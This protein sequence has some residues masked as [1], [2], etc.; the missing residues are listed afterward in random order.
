MDQEAALPLSKVEKSLAAD[1]D[2]ADPPAALA[3]PSPISATK[4]R[5]PFLYDTLLMSLCFALGMGSM[6]LSV[7]VVSLVVAEQVRPGLALVPPALQKLMATATAYPGARHKDRRGFTVAALVGS[8]GYLV[9]MSAVLFVEGAASFAVLCVG[10]LL[11]GVSDPFVQFL[12]FASSDVAPTKFKPKAISYVIAGGTLA[13]IL[14]PE[15]AHATVDAI[16]EKLYAGAYLAA[17]VLL[18]V[19]ALILAFAIDYTPDNTDEANTE[20]SEAAAPEQQEVGTTPKEVDERTLWSVVSGSTFVLAATTAAILQLTMI[21][22]MQ[23]IPITMKNEGFELRHSVRVI[24]GHILG[25]YIPSFFTGS[26]INTFGKRPM[27][28]AGTALNLLAAGCLLSDT[29]N[30]WPFFVCLTA[31]GVGW[32]WGEWISKH[33]SSLPR[34]HPPSLMLCRAGL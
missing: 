5:R 26:L 22:L 33:A 7:S 28:F 23:I 3:P 24:Q 11:A 9:A 34:T 19:Q 2:A 14:G 20:P 31:I 25:M 6:F 8:M 27:M 32:N 15:L 18:L 29:T 17:S 4:T 12:R 10:Y 30:F 21:A 1:L 16:P 13:A